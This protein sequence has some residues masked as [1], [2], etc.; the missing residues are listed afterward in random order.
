MVDGVKRERL[1]EGR[2]LQMMGGDG[3]ERRVRPRRGG[4]EKLWSALFS[5]LLRASVESLR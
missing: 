3:G 4:V 1:H 2:R 5:S